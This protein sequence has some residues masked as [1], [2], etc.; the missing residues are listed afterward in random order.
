MSSVLNVPE[1]KWLTASVY[2]LNTGKLPDEK[3][4][5]K[6]VQRYASKLSLRPH[7]DESES[8]RQLVFTYE[9]GL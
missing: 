5:L 7:P 9:D 4:L 8:E 2:F 6:A 3:K 1:D